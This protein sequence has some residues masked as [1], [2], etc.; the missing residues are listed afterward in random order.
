MREQYA[1][2]RQAAREM[3]RRRKERSKVMGRRAEEV[4]DMTDGR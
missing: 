1:A 2:A 4:V 3:S